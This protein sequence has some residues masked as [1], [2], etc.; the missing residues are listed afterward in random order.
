MAHH[1]ST[2]VLSC[3]AASFRV[4]VLPSKI[5]SNKYCFAFRQPS[6]L[7]PLFSSS[8]IICVE[9]FSSPVESQFTWYKPCEAQD[10]LLLT[11]WRL[12]CV[13]NGIT[14]WSWSIGFEVRRVQGLPSIPPMN[15][16]A[17][18]KSAQRPHNLSRDE[19]RLPSL[20]LMSV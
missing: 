13:V 19:G 18:R 17:R 12:G 8:E 7:I 15:Y 5:T 4:E 10:S 11:H 16:M 3:L 6:I 2:I 9:G 1:R 14:S 20:F